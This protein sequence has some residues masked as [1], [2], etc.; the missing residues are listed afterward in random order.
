MSQIHWIS[1]PICNGSRRMSIIEI[2]G[3]EKQRVRVPCNACGDTGKSLSVDNTKKK[4]PEPHN[5][6]E[7]LEEKYDGW[8]D[9]SNW[10]KVH[11]FR[12]GKPLCRLIKSPKYMLES[13]RVD[14]QIHRVCAQPVPEGLRNHPVPNVSKRTN[15]VKR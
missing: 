12:D 8:R 5:R 3:G 4:E 9:H 15:R 13:V 1:C 14:V 7:S 6:V 10:D 11:Y 2:T